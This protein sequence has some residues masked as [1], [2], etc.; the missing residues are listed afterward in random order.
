MPKFDI[1]RAKDA[2]IIRRGRLT[3]EGL[4]KCEISA[5]RET[6]GHKGDYVH[7]DLRVLEGPS[8]A[9]TEFTDSHSPE[10]ATGGGGLSRPQAVAR[11]YLR[12]QIAV[13][14]GY[15]YASSEADQVTQQVFDAS[16]TPADRADVKSPLVGRIVLVDARQHTTRAG[17]QIM[18]YD[19]LPYTGDDQR[20]VGK[21]IGAP[22]QAAKAAP[23]PP[24]PS[25]SSLPDGW[26]V[27][28][29]SPAHAW[30]PTTREVVEISKL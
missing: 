5:V 1:S 11:D 2:T 19:I 14:A 15:G 17:R 20:P 16:V 8:A 21:P 12:L 4:H 18:L 6:N 25:T 23:P 22:T 10:N 9:G 28:P 26:Q 24:P 13:A 3:H 30:N 29:S 7:F 27:H